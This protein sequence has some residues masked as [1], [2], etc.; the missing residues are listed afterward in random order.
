[1]NINEKI[2]YFCFEKVSEEFLVDYS[3]LN[4]KMSKKFLG[5]LKD[6]A[7][8]FEYKKEITDG[9]YFNNE[10]GGAH[11]QIVTINTEPYLFKV[12]V[13]GIDYSV[14]LR[15]ATIKKL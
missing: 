2:C 9:S 12:I 6:D 14:K 11:Y 3:L 1:M 8:I 5:I 10:N 7:L 4:H 15:I 13:N